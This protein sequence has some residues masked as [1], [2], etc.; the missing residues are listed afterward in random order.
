MLGAGIPQQTLNLHYR[1]RK[2]SL[3]AFSN[4]RYYANG[5][6]IFLAPDVNDR[7]VSLVRPAGFY[8]RDGTQ[9]NEGEAKAI[10]AEIVRRLT[11]GDPAVRTGSISVVTFNAEQQTLI[12]NLLDEECTAHRE[13][14]P[15]FSSA[16]TLEPVFVKNLETVQGDERDVLLFSVTYG[17]DRN[18]NV[19]MNF[20]LLNREGGERRLNVALTRARSEMLVST[21][22][23]DRIDLSRTRARAVA[24]L[25]HFLQ[26]AERGRA[27][28]G[29]AG[30][31]PVA[32]FES[33]FEAAVTEELRRKGWQV[34]P[35]V[36]VSSYRI[37]LGIV[38]LD[39]SGRYLAGI[40]CD[41]AMSHSSTVYG[42]A[43]KSTNR[44]LKGSAGRYSAS[45]PIG[46][47]TSPKPSKW[48]IRSYDNISKPTVS[49]G[50]HVLTP[51]DPESEC[52]KR[53]PDIRVQFF[54]GMMA[55][56]SR[57]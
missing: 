2:E 44:C 29:A 19:T 23:P 22:N 8:A 39:E 28:L 41:G 48:W 9:H 14:E 53:D 38:R 7:A 24:D 21:L 13:I 25:K 55:S 12:E 56:P 36:G 49:S 5:F 40:E 50:P 17:P 34:H 45:G 11:H 33:P 18:G 52:G 6:V 15:A 46:G 47:P 32:G 26:Y 51:P 1:S 30:P 4:E 20:G 42:N 16:D 37:G 31:G 27:A 57:V 35:R 54:T 43:T 3:I 10:V